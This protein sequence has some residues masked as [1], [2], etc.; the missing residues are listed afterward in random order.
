MEDYLLKPMPPKKNVNDKDKNKRNVRGRPRKKQV[1]KTKKVEPVEKIPEFADDSKKNEEIVLILPLNEN[2]ILK[3]DDNEDYTDIFTPTKTK[4]ITKTKTNRIKTKKKS[5]TDNQFTITDM[6]YES[7]D[8]DKPSYKDKKLIE[9]MKDEINE[10]KEKIK[11]YEKTYDNS[12]LCDKN[13]YKINIKLYDEENNKKINVKKTKIA[14]WWCTET[15]N[16]MPFFLPEKIV[17]DEF[18][19]IGNFCMPECAAA[20]NE[21]DLNDYKK[22][23]RYSMLSKLYPKPDNKIINL[24]PK[25]ELL[26][27]FGGP[28]DIRKYRLTACNHDIICRF[29]LPPM[30]PLVP[31]IEEVDMGKV[32]LKKNLSKDGLVLK[33]KKPLRTNNNKFFS[34]IIKY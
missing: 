24:S 14:C 8:D 21:Y 18:Y 34:S 22:N 25:R 12:G 33:R 32:Q 5:S 9:K 11:Y 29:M 2:D 1:S 6:G 7:S 26:K 15:F 3:L 10:L 4:T 16:N 23:D 31:I 30:K 20:Y 17:N 19:V 13:I 28:Y 27:K